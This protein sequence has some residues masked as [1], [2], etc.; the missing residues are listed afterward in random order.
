MNK[1]ILAISD[2]H[3]M[4]EKFNGLLEMVKYN[5]KEDQLILLGDYVDRGPEP[6]KTL[7]KV[8]ELVENGAI[9][10]RGNHEDMFLN[11][12]CE[13]E[14]G[15][16]NPQELALH[17]HNGGA[18][19]QQQYVNLSEDDQ[20]GI[21]ILLCKFKLIH[22]EDNFIFV[23]AGINPCFPIDKQDPS[24][25]VWIRDEFIYGPVIEGKTVIFGHT[26]TKY[27][28]GHFNIWH[29]DG[30]ICIDCGAAYGGKLACLKIPTM[31]EYYC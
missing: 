10:L 9:A 1:R 25:L 6:I 30:K 21:R 17:I 28:S 19:T 11:V 2:I 4:L 13:M 8:A 5:P 16:S 20:A 24:D 14:R 22:E 15:N 3:G 26:P 23:H 12:A 7:L 31:R 29:G 18:I 27:M